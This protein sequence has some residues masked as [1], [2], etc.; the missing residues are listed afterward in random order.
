MTVLRPWTPDLVSLDLLLSVVELGSVGKAAAAH[1]ISTPSASA[2]L[3]RLERQLAVPVLVRGARGTTLTPAGEAIVAWAAK[4]VEAA[5]VMTD[6][7]QTLR[8]NQGARL[9]IAASLTIAEYVLP[10]W[11]LTFRRTHPDI[12]MV[13]S[14]ANSR[15]VCEEVRSGAVDLGFIESPQPPE[16]LTAHAVGTDRLALVASPEFISD[17]GGTE[18]E[19]EKLLELPIL[20]REA[21]SGT[22]D[23]F[24]LALSQ[25]LGREPALPLAVAL[26][27]T[28]TILATA[29][30][31]GG[32]GVVSHRAV[33]SE[34][35]SGG[36]QELEVEGLRPER[37]LRAVWV[38]RQPAPLAAEFIAYGAGRYREEVAEVGL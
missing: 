29:R 18:I 14:V 13:A 20:L 11:L 8:A 27:T 23:T 10:R 37:L 4:V 12:E 28:T 15:A 26:G 25:R 16:G 33:A 21:G 38:G 9:R 1:G 7:V 34:L 35:S 24:L 19:P 30:A 32:V 2:R 22:R 3:T 36:L 31:G 5:Q 17:L 6:G